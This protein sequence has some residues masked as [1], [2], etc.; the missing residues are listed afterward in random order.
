[1]LVISGCG[2][3]TGAV[4][5]A[6]SIIQGAA[7][8]SFRSPRKELPLYHMGFFVT[9][10]ALRCDSEKSDVIGLKIPLNHGW[11]TVSQ[12]RYRS[13]EGVHL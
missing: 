10:L 12:K 8:N 4:S 11:S 6:N 1:M 13:K 5:N 7:D 3:G 2:G 9:I